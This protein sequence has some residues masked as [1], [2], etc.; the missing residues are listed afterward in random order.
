ME[1]KAGIIGRVKYKNHNIKRLPN[2][3]NTRLN[4]DLGWGRVIL[5]MNDEIS[6]EISVAN[7]Y[8]MLK[9]AQDKLMHDPIED[10][11]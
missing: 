10:D 6:D 11:D 8:Y 7:G 9:V 1:K 2:S 3:P 4:I 5:V